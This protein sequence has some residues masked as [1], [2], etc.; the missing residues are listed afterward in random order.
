MPS[1]SGLEEVNWLGRNEADRKT[2]AQNKIQN[3]LNMAACNIKTQCF[4]KAVA[5]TT[6]V[7]R[8]EP[9]NQI[10]LWRRARALA[11]PINA[12]V[13]DFKDALTDLGQLVD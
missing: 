8:T 2:I 10:A 12:K 6:E 1:I 5:V 7:L 4:D 9:N 3:L 11:A 13:P